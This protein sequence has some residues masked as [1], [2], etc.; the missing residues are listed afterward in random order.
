M[1][2][3]PAAASLL[4]HGLAASTRNRAGGSVTTFCTFCAFSFGPNIPCLPASS[5]SSGSAACQPRIAPTTQPSMN[6]VI[7]ALTMSTL[8]STSMV[9]AVAISSRP[10]VAT[11]TSMVYKAAFTLAFACFLC[12]REVVWER[13]SDPAVI[14]WV[15]SVALEPG[16]A[17][18]TLLA[19]KTD[20]FQLGVKVVAPLVA[21]SLSPLTY[22]GHSFRRGAATW[23]ASLGADA[24][25]IQC[26]GQWNSDCF[27]C[28]I[29]HSAAEHQDLSITALYCLWDG[30]LIPHTTSWHDVG[31]S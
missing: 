13:S 11:N 14:L 31:S 25:T 16:H 22:A 24:D 18:I 9:S 1:G 27:Q 4:W 7:S 10:C 12:S 30:A 26:L 21:S 17:V 15:A 20:P 2:L 23:A 5:S 6:L 29:D 28:Y 8:A 3:S 19:S